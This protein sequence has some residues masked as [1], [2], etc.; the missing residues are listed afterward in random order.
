MKHKYILLWI[1]A[2]LVLGGC[3]ASMRIYSDQDPGGRFDQYHSYSF[4]D[5]TD[6]NK[7]T[8]PGMELERIRV[9]MARELEKRGLEYVEKGGDVSVQVTV[10]HR[11]AVDRYWHYPRYVYME[12]AIAVDMYDNQN[13]KHVWHCTAVD[14]LEYDPD[15]RASHLPQVAA[16]IFEKYPV[17]VPATTAP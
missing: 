9:A 5:F 13:N 10:Y 4:L 14:E 17:P 7:K 15:K 12:R 2:M 11:Q 6:G 8:I 3:G 16:S 1:A